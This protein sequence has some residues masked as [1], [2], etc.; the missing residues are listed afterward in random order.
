MK[1]KLTSADSQLT[2]ES[3][4]TEL[5]PELKNFG[6]GPRT[7]KRKA[8]DKSG[9]R[10]VWTDTPADRER[11]AKEREE[12]KKSTSKDNEVVLSGRDKRLAEQVTS[13]NVSVIASCFL[14]LHF[15]PVFTLSFLF[16]LAQLLYMTSPELDPPAQEG[17]GPTRTSPEEGHEDGQGDGTPL[18]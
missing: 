8:D 17:H 10:S 12:T 18:L 9:D 5:P 16:L 14:L 4:M 11:K 6:F 2:R 7:F 1:E 3:W 15:L 13:Y